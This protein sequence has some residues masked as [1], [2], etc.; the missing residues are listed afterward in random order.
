MCAPFEN[1]GG[2]AGWLATVHL[3]NERTRVG[4]ATFAL[5]FWNYGGLAGWLPLPTIVPEEEHKCGRAHP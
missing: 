3:D 4:L 1:S 2:L 5:L